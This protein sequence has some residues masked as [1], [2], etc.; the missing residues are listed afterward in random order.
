MPTKEFFM[1]KHIEV[2]LRDLKLKIYGKICIPV[3]GSFIH[4]KGCLN[5]VVRSKVTPF[6]REG[7]TEGVFDFKVSTYFYNREH[8]LLK[9][10][11]TLIWKSYPLWWSNHP[12]WWESPFCCIDA[13]KPDF[14]TVKE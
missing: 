8:L 7:K 9:Q 4:N 12:R 13:S 11:F 5:Q 14:S 1:E 6:I 2:D 3:S 10:S